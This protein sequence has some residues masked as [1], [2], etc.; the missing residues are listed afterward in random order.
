[1]NGFK[2]AMNPLIRKSHAILF[3]GLPCVVE[4]CVQYLEKE[5]VQGLFLKNGNAGNIRRLRQAFKNNPDSKDKEKAIALNS[6]K[7]TQ[8]TVSCAKFSVHVR[9]LIFSYISRSCPP[10]DQISAIHTARCG[11]HALRFS[12]V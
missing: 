1:M 5:Y 4:R 2:D 8:M 10:K 9:Q 11:C 6:V 3:Q 7:H 12:E